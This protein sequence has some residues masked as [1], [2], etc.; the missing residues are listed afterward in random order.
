MQPT[1]RMTLP[2]EAIVSTIRVAGTIAMQ[3]RSRGLHVEAKGRQDF[4]TQA[5]RAVE[6]H[7][8]ARLME[9]LP[10]SEFVGEEGGGPTEANLLW[11]VDPIDGTTNYIRGLPHWCVSVALMEAGR[12][13]FGAI[14]APVLED[15]YLAEDCS[16]ATLN[17]KP[18][19]RERVDPASA[20]VNVG[21]S[22]RQTP[23][24]Y[25]TLISGL[26]E[27][28]LDHR[29]LGSGALGLA[30]TASGELD[31]SVEGHV[32]PWDVAGGLLI[33]RE[34]GCVVNDFFRSGAMRDGN[35]AIAAAPGVEDFVFGAVEA[36][37][38]HRV[39]RLPSTSDD[40][41]C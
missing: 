32:R 30:Q 6:H 35:P 28:H 37:L 14:L 10:G 8:R 23:G 38:G 27:H 13:R 11:I 29:L 7:L 25:A 2:V 34:A 36:A 18:I 16:G 31:G 21:Q 15:L 40:L 41:Y 5:D 39:P 9:L 19:L 33:A 3:E 20:L 1:L 26:R 17:G 4:V 24:F 12:L 22:K